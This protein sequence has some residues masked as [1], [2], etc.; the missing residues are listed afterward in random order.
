MELTP[1]I[2]ATLS[3]LLVAIAA[4]M[5]SR[6]GADLI[7]CG[8]LAV[9][10]LVDRLIG[11]VVTLEGALKG[12]ANPGMITVAIMF[13]V[14]E[15]LQQTG[16]VGY[17]VQ[18]FLGQP[19]SR[20]AALLRMMIP[21]AAMSAFLNNTP[22]VAILMPVLDEWAKKYRLAI[23]H[24]LL[25]LSYAAILG[26]LCT[27]IGTS[28]TLV[29]NGM[30]LKT[31]GLRGLTMFELGYVGL[32]CCVVGIIYVLLTSKWLLPDR[33]PI[34][35]QM[36]NPREY[37]VE[38][39]IE[40]TSPLVGRT[41]EGAGL[42]S[43]PGMYLMEID[44]GG[45]V[46]AAV[47]PQ[48]VLQAEDRLVFVGVVESVVDLQRIPGLT[49]ATNQLFKLDSPRS[50]RCLIEAV[51]SDT[52]PVA[53]MSIRAAR[54]RTRYNAAVIAV[55]R[56]GQRLRGK[57]G[58]IELQAGDTLLI[59]AHPTFADVQ[60]NSRDFYLVSKVE[61]STPPRHHKAWIALVILTL[62]VGIA[63]WIDDMLLAS[64]FAA[65]GMLASRCIHGNEARRSIDWSVLVTI[66]AGLGLGNAVAESGAAR[67]V[68]VNLISLAGDNPALALSIIY[69]LTMVLTNLIT[70]KAAAGVIY[71]L[72][73]ETAQTLGVDPMPFAIAVIVASAA[74]FATPM[75]Y[76]TNMMVFGPGGY[77]YP[78]YVRFGGPLSL[79]LWAVAIAIIPLAWPFTTGP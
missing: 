71:F 2:I 21:T 79:L 46:M 55:A 26:G 5:T 1:Q 33:R 41:I 36:D 64:L 38:M 57:I 13:V 56:N 23:S 39:V 72:A 47:S 18:Q 12:F 11:G 61:N 42:R 27:L 51:V 77:R 9:L 43:L 60:R 32:P 20:R 67:Y 17:W 75:G 34:I 63:L 59:E 28:T 76:Q 35:D 70:A 6:A 30:M 53:N 31:P 16:A 10:L 62:M 50:E 52:C 22:V 66:A 48:E 73:I 37:T 68:S 65:A 49:P 3:V 4:L 58:D 45:H 44:R 25:P 69:G 24:L 54:F 19:K 15:G 8:C 78:D 14:A 7:L 74:S 29:V 40:P